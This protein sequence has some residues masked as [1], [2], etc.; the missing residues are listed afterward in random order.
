M[1]APLL[2]G[3]TTK[4]ASPD[5]S[6]T[7]LAYWSLCRLFP[8]LWLALCG[9][10]HGQLVWQGQEGAGH[11]CMEQSHISGQHAGE[12]C[13]HLIHPSWAVPGRSAAACLTLVLCL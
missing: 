8:G 13:G 4:L 12:L 6:P 3:S 1:L 10:H 2:L 7:R 5:D 9:Q 11:G